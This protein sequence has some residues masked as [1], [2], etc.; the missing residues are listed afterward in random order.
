MKRILYLMIV[1]VIIMTACQPK[2]KTVPIDKMALKGVVA[3]LIDKFHSYLNAKDVNG[4]VSFLTDDGLYCG[5]DSKELLDKATL[6]NIMV[7][8]FSDTSFVPNYKIDKRE[9]RIASDGNVAIVIDQFY[10]ESFSPKIPVRFV[11]H[12]IKTGDEWK[13]DFYSVSFIPNNE[14]IPKLNK[15]LE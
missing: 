10:I 2:I 7:Q 3:S 13:I 5:T 6:T 4:M 1:A 11:F 15:A 9:I 12:L 8:T 14:D